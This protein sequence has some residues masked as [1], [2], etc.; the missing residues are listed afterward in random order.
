MAKP[1]LTEAQGEAQHTQPQPYGH[2]VP[3][4]CPLP[5]LSLTGSRGFSGTAGVEEPLVYFF[6]TKLKKNKKS[7][8]R[9]WEPVAT[10]TVHPAGSSSSGAGKGSR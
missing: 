9:L 4:L 2:L 5:S 10:A 7:G 1:G 6:L 8:F 3:V